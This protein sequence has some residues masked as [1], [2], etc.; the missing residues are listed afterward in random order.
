MV[1]QA[2]SVHER[3][4]STGAIIFCAFALEGF[5]NHVGAELVPKW[6]ELFESL[7]PE[8]KLV[9]LSERHAVKI[10]FGQPPFEA[11]RT[12]FRVRN[13]MAHPKTKNHD[14]V[15][16]QGKEWLEI[17]GN[18]WP[19]EMWEKLCTANQASKLLEHTQNIIGLLEKSLPHE[20][21]PD[22]ILSEHV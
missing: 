12:I 8:A 22:F 13:Q 14:Y 9:Y 11:F 10:D 15:E 4:N 6:G 2:K 20:S 5:L 18:R 1:E 7:S 17:G 16:K 3:E 19:V 21:V